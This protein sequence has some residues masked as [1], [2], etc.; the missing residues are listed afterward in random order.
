MMEQG[1]KNNQWGLHEWRW[2]TLCF[3]T[4]IHLAFLLINALEISPVLFLLGTTLAPRACNIWG[5]NYN[6]SL[7][8]GISFIRVTKLSYSDVASWK[9]S[10]TEKVK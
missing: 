8:W 6:F 1:A 10:V 7:G 2:L 9:N 3:K 4:V 5:S